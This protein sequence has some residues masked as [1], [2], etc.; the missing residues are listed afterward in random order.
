MYVLTPYLTKMNII[1]FGELSDSS[2]AYSPLT[3]LFVYLKNVL[4]TNR[5]DYT[6]E[7]QHGFSQSELQ[8]VWE[9]E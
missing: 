4:Y 2:P 1:P 3:V 6:L 8:G 5:L 7:S 9:N